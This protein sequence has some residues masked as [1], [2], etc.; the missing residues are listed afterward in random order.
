MGERT[1][2]YRGRVWVPIASDVAA[3]YDRNA[4]GDW[5]LMGLVVY[6]PNTAKIRGVRLRGRDQI[7]G[8]AD[9]ISSIRQETPPT[10]QQVAEA[11]ER[12]RANDEGWREWHASLE[13]Q[14]SAVLAAG[15]A[16]DE[17][18]AP[19]LLKRRDG[20]APDDFY[21]RIAKAHKAL[22]AWTGR[23]TQFLANRAGVPEGTAAAWVSR[24]RARGVYDD[25]GGEQP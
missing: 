16:A 18:A 7:P 2:D 15:K 20:E 13:D 24:A 19:E 4:L 12:V 5:V 14:R 8:T 6:G 22:A 3:G 21:R 23:P 1:T 25:E 11:W 9:F 17:A 10:P